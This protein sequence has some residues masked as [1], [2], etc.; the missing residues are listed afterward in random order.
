MKR[1]VVLLLITSCTLLNFSCE[2]DCHCETNTTPAIEKGSVVFWTNDPQVLPSC[3]TLTI[4]LNTGQQSNITGFY[5][6]APAN[7]TNQ[8]GGY[9]YIDAGTYTYQIIP[10]NSN[11]PIGTGT[12]TVIGNQCNLFRI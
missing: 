6:A 5:F 11:C 8:F 9:F 1:I 12:V 10:Q 7:C 2:K 3:G 4:R